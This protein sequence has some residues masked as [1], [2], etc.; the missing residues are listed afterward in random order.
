VSA[1]QAAA[2]LAGSPY[3]M[4][5]RCAGDLFGNRTSGYDTME[6]FQCI[7]CG[8]GIAVPYGTF[9]REYAG[10]YEVPP[11]RCELLRLRR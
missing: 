1:L 2:R 5:P 3:E 6:T 10:V 8:C 7:A 4:C 11:D 9:Q